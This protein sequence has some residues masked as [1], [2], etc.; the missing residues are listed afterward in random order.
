MG[1]SQPWNDARAV[2]R[3][4]VKR[5]ATILELLNCF[6]SA[7][8]DPNHRRT[9]G[10]FEYRLQLLLTVVGTLV[11]L[12]LISE[13]LLSV[14]GR[15]VAYDEVVPNPSARDIESYFAQQAAGGSVSSLSYPCTSASAS[16]SNVSTWTAQEDSFCAALRSAT[17]PAAPNSGLV[18]E[19]T[20]M[21]ASEDNTVC[22]GKPGEPAF[23]AFVDELA[24]LGPP[25]GLLPPAADRPAYAALAEHAQ[26]AICG[27]AFG[28]V[29][30]RYFTPPVPEDVSSMTSAC[31]T[32][33]DGGQSGG[34]REEARPFPAAFLHARQRAGVVQLHQTRALALLQASAH[35]CRSLFVLREGFLRRVRHV[36]LVTP[37]ALAPAQ[38]ARAVERAWEEALAEQS[39]LVAPLVP[40]TAPDDVAGPWTEPVNPPLAFEWQGG[41]ATRLQPP[42]D[43]PVSSFPLSSRLPFVRADY[44]AGGS[45]HFYVTAQA[46]PNR[47]DISS[48]ERVPVPAFAG[49]M[50]V[51]ARSP[52]LQ[53]YPHIPAD[54]AFAAWHG[55][56]G[57]GLAEGWVPVGDD[58][59]SL[60]DAC[61]EGTPLEAHVINLRQLALT[62]GP[63]WQPSGGV[64]GPNFSYPF[65]Q[66]ASGVSSPPMCG[67]GAPPSGPGNATLATEQPV[68]FSLPLRCPSLLRWLGRLRSNSTYAPRRSPLRFTVGQFLDTLPG[69]NPMNL[70]AS[71]EEWPAA[72]R[73]LLRTAGEGDLSD[74]VSLLG[75][76]FFQ[77]ARPAFAHRPRAHYDACRPRSCSYTFIKRRG[78]SDLALE[79]ISVYGGTVATVFS[80]FATAG[81]WV[82][83]ANYARRRRA[84]KGRQRAP[85]GSNPSIPD[86]VAL[87]LS[88][89][90]S[91]GSASEAAGSAP[92][93]SSSSS[94]G[95]GG[96]TAAPP[97]ATGDG[98]GVNA[99]LP[100]PPLPDAGRVLT[101]NP[102]VS[103]REAKP[104]HAP[105]HWQVPAPGSG[106][107]RTAINTAPL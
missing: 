38:L 4:P 96:G 37:L 90:T 45:R 94:G 74:R 72:T 101:F 3:K 70:S 15:P 102:V 63:F 40:G 14:A 71:R 85:G 77:D 95:T 6:G 1:R 55:F 69:R 66:M 10:R 107:G 61:A 28:S 65:D 88:P 22:V 62:A 23:E 46:S 64:W 98:H 84:E 92:A 97:A 18:D 59:L 39:R 31:G 56:Y 32:G 27:T 17:D 83:Y 68:L 30:Q 29:P 103:G 106:S 50:R 93:A 51:V 25:T 75:R 41:D 34:A 13:Q 21:L 53:A 20:A 43:L 35:A 105:P 26:R 24:R 47:S 91:W 79:G 54:P 2:S 60:I 49:A 99:A 78:A 104:R 80:F 57:R 5:I 82:S 12:T 89:S 58:M 7:H 33:S 87:H 8:Y 44:I 73:A 42:Y 48:S 81:L 36:E 76:L 9:I 19:L 67:F 52:S 100:P 86:G 16:L 11:A